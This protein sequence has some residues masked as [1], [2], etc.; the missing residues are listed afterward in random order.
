MNRIITI[1][2]AITLFSG[3]TQAQQSPPPAVQ[4]YGHYLLIQAALAGDSLQGIGEAA[5]TIV[6]LVRSDA[7]LP[8]GIAD[9]A[10]KVSMAADLNAA[11]VAFKEL[12][13]ALIA[14]RQSD[15]TLMERFYVIHCSMAFDNQGASWL[16]ATK[17]VSNPY[18]GASILRCGTLQK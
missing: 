6:K 2:T 18:F 16:Q 15:R 9:A 5:D 13:D 11:R 7:K 17:T 4:V 1:L 14:H 12:S 10:A 8:A 3:L